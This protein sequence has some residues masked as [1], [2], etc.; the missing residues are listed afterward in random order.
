[1]SAITATP[2]SAGQ[3][4][5]DLGERTSGDGMRCE[6]ADE[7]RMADAPSAKAWLVPSDPSAPHTG[8]ISSGPSFFA[9]FTRVEIG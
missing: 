1:M 5:V 8:S 2:N 6:I 9:L 7:V 3:R 4:A